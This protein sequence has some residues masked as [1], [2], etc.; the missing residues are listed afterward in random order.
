ML[1]YFAYAIPRRCFPPTLLNSRVYFCFDI[2]LCICG[3]KESRQ[4]FCVATQWDSNKFSGRQNIT[5]Y[6]EWCWLVC[7]LDVE[8]FT[9]LFK[10]R[11]SKPKKTEN[12]MIWGQF[13]RLIFKNERAAAHRSYFKARCTYDNCYYYV[14]LGLNANA[15]KPSVIAHH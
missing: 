12:V 4:C 13:S 9:T 11:A 15:P 14:C 5:L 1:N 3:H 6:A 10:F 7:C 8:K 2:I